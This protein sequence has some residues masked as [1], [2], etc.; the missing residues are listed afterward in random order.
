[1][2]N[3]Q[4]PMARRIFIQAQPTLTTLLNTLGVWNPAGAQYIPVENNALTLSPNESRVPLDFVHGSPSPLGSIQGRKRGEW[5]LTVPIF[6]NG[7]AGVPPDTD[8]LFQSLFGG[9][10]VSV[11]GSGI[12]NA[13]FYSFVDFANVPLTILAFNIGSN[14]TASSYAVG[15]IVQ[16]ATFTINTDILAMALSGESV[17]VAEIDTFPIL[18]PEAQAGLTQFP[19]APSSFVSNGVA[20]HGYGGFF[21]CTIGAS[22]F[23]IPLQGTNLTFQVNT[24]VS[25]YGD[26]V[27]TFYPGAVLYGPRSVTVSL[28]F[29]NNDSSVL[30]ALKQAARRNT[31]INIAYQLLGNPA[32]QRFH[33]GANNVQLIPASLRDNNN[34]V[35]CDFGSSLAAGSA[36]VSNDFTI[37]FA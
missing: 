12:G 30:V 4:S 18:D 21:Y 33:I 31:P 7:T 9:V 16:R 3:F 37:G 34:S 13:W 10:G 26:F 25:L 36:G 8:L 15:A 17:A 6:P 1:M 24:G 2:P 14:N 32:G 29:L 28:S 23:P 19:T 20:T 27:D 22:S 5:G 11:P 35:T